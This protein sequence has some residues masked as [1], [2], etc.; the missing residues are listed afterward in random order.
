MLDT[1]NHLLDWSNINKFAKTSTDQASTSE[2]RGSKASSANHNTYLAGGMVHITS[3]L[4][5]YT[6]I[7]EVVECVYARHVYQQQL[8]LRL[9]DQRHPDNSED[10]PHTTLDMLQALNEEGL[11]EGINRH[12]HRFSDSTIVILDIEPAVDW[13][14]EAPAGAVRRII[15]TLCGNAF[16]FTTQGFVKVTAYQEYPDP[17]AP[18]HRVI[19]I[20]I[21]DTVSGNGYDFLRHNLFTSFS[22]ESINMPGTGIGLS[23]AKRF[24]EALGGS[25][26]VESQIGEGTYIVVK[27][28]IPVSDLRASIA[29]DPDNFN[30]QVNAL[31]RLRVSVAGFSTAND[32]WSSGKD[33]NMLNEQA[34]MG[35]VVKSG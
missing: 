24:I 20:D 18:K 16:K 17:A 19:H 27:L 12:M 33:G 32:Y 8:M 28:P 31:T 26:N 29:R 23:L 34:L 7:E 6:L 11:D 15:M 2:F 21:T 14:F 10:R 9:D 3:L 13:T 5:L 35:G 22:K 30:A 25:I 1:I 4:N